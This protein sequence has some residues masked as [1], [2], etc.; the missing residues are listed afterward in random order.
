MDRGGILCLIEEQ[1]MQRYL[2][3]RSI[4]IEP[5]KL[6]AEVLAEYTREYCNCFDV[7]EYAVFHMEHEKANFEAFV[8]EMKPFLLDK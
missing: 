1:K 7:I 4:C 3:I 8:E 5:T 6:V 2:K